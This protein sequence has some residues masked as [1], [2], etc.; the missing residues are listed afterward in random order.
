QQAKDAKVNALVDGLMSYFGISKETAMGIIFP[1]WKDADGNTQSEDRSGWTFAQLKAAYQSYLDQ[2]A[3]DKAYNQRLNELEQ[4]LKEAGYTVSRRGTENIYFE[5][6]NNSGLVLKVY[7]ED[8]KD[9][10]SINKIF[11][12]YAQLKAITGA[13]VTYKADSNGNWYF[14]VK[15]SDCTLSVYPFDETGNYTFD[16]NKTKQIV[17]LYSKFKELDSK[18]YNVTIK[19]DENGYMYFEVTKNNVTV[20]IYPFDE[21]GNVVSIFNAYSIQQI[22][23][24]YMYNKLGEDN[25]GTD[26][27]GF[28]QK[29]LDV[30][31]DEAKAYF[32]QLNKNKETSQSSTVTSEEGTTTTT[33]TKLTFWDKIS[34]FFVSIWN[35]VRS[36]FGLDPLALKEETTTTSS[37]PTESTEVSENTATESNVYSY[38]ENGIKVEIK[39]TDTYDIN[40]QKA[41]VYVKV[42]YDAEGNYLGV[43]EFLNYNNEFYN[44][45]ISNEDGKV[46]SIESSIVD[47]QEDISFV[48]SE[49]NIKTLSGALV[50][51]LVESKLKENNY[52]VI[53]NIVY[54]VSNNKSLTQIGIGTVR[55]NGSDTAVF[56]ADPKLN[57]DGT[58]SLSIVTEEGKVIAKVDSL[59]IMNSYGNITTDDIEYMLSNATKINNEEYYSFV[60]R[61]YD[62][63]LENN[64]KYEI[65]IDTDGNIYYTYDG[66][67]VNI[68]YG[69]F[70]AIKNA[71]AK[72][73]NVT[74]SGQISPVRIFVGENVVLH[75][76]DNETITVNT[77]LLE[78]YIQGST[79]KITGKNQN[80]QT[81][82]LTTANLNKMVS[83]FK[84]MGLSKE[85]DIWVSSS[86]VKFSFTDESKTNGILSVQS[87]ENEYS[88]TKNYVAT[89]VGY[90]DGLPIYQTEKTPVS[91]TFGMGYKDMLA[92]SGF[93][94]KVANIE[95]LFGEIKDYCGYNLSELT[96]SKTE[97]LSETGEVIQTSWAAYSDSST[98]VI[99][100]T[101]DG[102]ID[103]SIN[104][105]YAGTVSSYKGQK[106]DCGIRYNLLNDDVNQDP[107]NLVSIT[108]V[109]TVVLD[110]YKGYAF[111]EDRTADGYLTS[112]Y[113]I[114]MEDSSKLFSYEDDSITWQ[115]TLDTYFADW[116][117]I[118]NSSDMENLITSVNS[119][120]EGNI[121][122][123]TRVEKFAYYLEDC[124]LE[125]LTD[126]EKSKLK[127]VSDE[128]SGALLSFL[129]IP[130]QTQT[131]LVD[132]DGKITESLISESFFNGIDWEKQRIHSYEII[133]TQI[134]NETVQFR[135][136][137]RET[138]FRGNVLQQYEIE[139]GQYVSGVIVPEYD[140][141]GIGLKSYAVVFE[142][143]KA[144]VTSSTNF[145]GRISANTIVYEN[146]VNTVLFAHERTQIED[147][148][149]LGI[150]DDM[151]D[152]TTGNMFSLEELLLTEDGDLKDTDKIQSE[153]SYILNNAEGRNVITLSNLMVDENGS[154]IKAESE[155]DAT[156]FEKQFGYPSIISYS[157]YS[158]EE[159]TIDNERRQL[160]IGH[161]TVVVSYAYND[162]LNF[163]QYGAKDKNGNLV[164]DVT[165]V[166]NNSNYISKMNNLQIVNTGTEANKVISLVYTVYTNP[167]FNMDNAFDGLVRRFQINNDSVFN[168]QKA[169]VAKYI[170]QMSGLKAVSFK[171]DGLKYFEIYDY[172]AS[173]TVFGSI[174]M[175]TY[176]VNVLNRMG[177]AQYGYLINNDNTNFVKD[178]ERKDWAE[179]IDDLSVVDNTVTS[180]EN[181]NN[182]S[183]AELVS[184]VKTRNLVPFDKNGIRISRVWSD[185]YISYENGTRY[186][187]HNYY[188]VNHL[189]TGDNPA[190]TRFRYIYDDNGVLVRKEQSEIFSDWFG[191]FNKFWVG[192]QSFYA[193]NKVLATIIFT[194]IPVLGIAFT[195]KLASAKR[196]YKKKKKM[197]MDSLNAPRISGP[198]ASSTLAQPKII[199]P[200]L[201]QSAS[202]LIL[203]KYEKLW[204][205]RN[206]YLKR[207]INSTFISRFI[208]N[209]SGITNTTDNLTDAISKS[210]LST[211]N[212][213]QV[214]FDDYRWWIRNVMSQTIQ[215]GNRD[216]FIK[217]NTGSFTQEDLV[218]FYYIYIATMNMRQDDMAFRNMLFFNAKKM[219]QEGKT[220]QIG[221][222]IDT[223]SAR[224]LNIVENGL[225]I[226]QQVGQMEAMNAV[227]S[228]KKLQK[229]IAFYKKNK[230]EIDELESK[231]KK[232]GADDANFEKLTDVMDGYFKKYGF[233]TLFG[234]KGAGGRGKMKPDETLTYYDID[235]I[236]RKPAYVNAYNNMISNYVESGEY[237]RVNSNN[238]DARKLSFEPKML[239][240]RAYI[241]H[242]GNLFGITNLLGL[243][244]ALTNLK[245]VVVMW[246]TNLS[247]VGGIITFMQVLGSVGVLSAIGFG[248]LFIVAGL[249]LTGLVYG[250]L[251]IIGKALQ[252]N[253]VN[254]FYGKTVDNSQDRGLESKDRDDIKTA[255]KAM[256]KRWAGVLSVKTIWEVFLL[257]T[258]V[259]SIITTLG[260]FSSI[261]AMSLTGI[262]LMSLVN[263]VLLFA[264][265]SLLG[266]ST[267]IG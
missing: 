223:E 256:V 110:L 176:E 247:L 165:D 143:G 184:D 132:A 198:E 70:Y 102:Y 167:N 224:F 80:G 241:P 163:D 133:D 174:N 3:K 214:M 107:M 194:I 144:Y 246:L 179:F 138:D 202:D 15:T 41:T 120:G 244:Q 47:E 204:G 26:G 159:V 200:E 146:N 44:R 89:I 13:T 22:V 153:K 37:S 126:E 225:S 162:S 58:Y 2:Q 83:S 35:W 87:S 195:F 54:A 135:K 151:L 221:L 183:L 166:I 181:E 231:Y 77:S 10:E 124:N 216:N 103:F 72:A 245:G 55:I 121:W 232:A 71:E 210:L 29:R 66:R 109:G 191:E 240:F 212:V 243:S 32:D 78:K 76:S 258:V 62:E 11:D 266:I 43:E 171:S 112:K 117:K 145:N 19:T 30:R 257:N 21:A 63:N 64:S 88:N 68:N 154:I 254:E 251:V 115:M 217:E 85:G 237:Q 226:Q 175:N 147:L 52:E 234:V 199:S 238:T 56:I 219:I 65:H 252:K 93:S 49:N 25:F 105:E 7:L 84:E 99:K 222:M 157:K 39:Q 101:P 50:S 259:S 81:V 152:V 6:S 118:S 5:V 201:K 209:D 249:A 33:T 24:V 139:N 17:E 113:Y 229:A 137:E 185:M 20:K 168:E 260:G 255:K 267:Y 74:A 196:E 91:Q 104:Y 94:Y 40:G 187:N 160:N 53:G 250:G 27:T 73:F 36:L 86:N 4:K 38:E 186:V 130:L 1:E 242:S 218:L 122:S 172:M 149:P 207:A 92:D 16:I 75:I 14:E 95:G 265:I 51:S 230:A 178:S 211:G 208:K 97:V 42:F 128:Y 9:I 31:L 116:M 262:G 203:D 119:L 248:G 69:E 170:S 190:M 48:Y 18:I 61:N 59:K 23:D 106:L 28:M 34:N 148:N 236:F 220:N 158:Q 161:P 233:R 46:F 164:T 125:N 227:K 90:K 45:Y 57:A 96:W 131:Y 189:N 98:P 239:P 169:T 192:L 79:T 129:G 82:T 100:I 8:F 123:V 264:V 188:E 215:V 136:Y 263:P 134:E 114:T 213:D 206:D 140:Q 111:I 155:S 150:S 67:K 253:T 180:I 193:Q 127:T 173:Q 142:D 60:V 205:V 197:I 235:A 228:N 12:T 261:T 108:G 156:D 141:Y 177:R 182:S